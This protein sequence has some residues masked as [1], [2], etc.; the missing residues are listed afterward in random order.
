MKEED[1][2]LT[3]ESADP[4]K[5]KAA[6]IM[7]KTDSVN[8]GNSIYLELRDIRRDGSMGAGKPV[9]K[10]FIQGMLESFSN[11]YRNIPHGTI[12]ENMI[13]CDTRRGQSKMVWYNAPRKRTRFFADKLGL[14]DGEYY[15]PGT[16]YYVNENTL[17]VFCF[18]GKKPAKNKVL[19]GVP[20]FNV[21]SSGNVCMGSAKVI[22]PETKD[23]S[24]EDVMKAWERA[25]WNSR[26]VHTNGS[27]STKENLIE[28][29]KKY[30]SKPFDT[31]D[32]EPWNKM[33]L[34]ELLNKISRQ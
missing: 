21:Y 7:F 5:P 15:V 19:L 8:Y 14:E 6:L 2:L 34:N 23:L 10:E 17:S 32:L 31:K 29:I 13:Y 20:Y 30:K 26:D 16:L 28:T 27:P 1:I 25:F 33:T 9:S 22:I 18:E 11:E 3:S 24:Y 4:Y 12:P